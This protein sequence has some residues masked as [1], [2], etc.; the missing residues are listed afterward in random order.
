MILI[1]MNKLKF[2][3]IMLENKSMTYLVIYLLKLTKA[4]SNP[5]NKSP[6]TKN[7]VILGSKNIDMIKK[8]KYIGKLPSPTMSLASP[9][10]FILRIF[11]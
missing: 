2:E 9:L 7:I 10:Y 1:N 4:P 5:W 11:L 6:I 8:N 3:I